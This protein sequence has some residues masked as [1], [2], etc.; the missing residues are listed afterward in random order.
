MADRAERRA[1]GIAGALALAAALGLQ[2]PSAGADLEQ[3]AG[4]VT[5]KDLARRTLTI[6]DEHVLQVAPTTRIESAEGARLT[7]EQVPVAPRAGGG[8]A[9]VREAVAEY[10]VEERGR[11]PVLYWIVV[12]G[13]PR[14]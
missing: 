11:R 12:G 6:D 1:A 7:L 10:E 4:L 8:F 3:G 9:V 14:R 2:A 13:E 5:G